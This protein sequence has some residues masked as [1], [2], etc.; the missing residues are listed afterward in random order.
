LILVPWRGRGVPW[1]L[2]DRVV[3]RAEDGKAEKMLGESARTSINAGAAQ[4]WLEAQSAVDVWN[5]RRG[6]ASGSE[7]ERMSIREAVEPLEQRV[8]EPSDLLEVRFTYEI[9]EH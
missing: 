8:Q 2:V 1:W 6:T 5:A 7:I 4:P 3:E 9:V